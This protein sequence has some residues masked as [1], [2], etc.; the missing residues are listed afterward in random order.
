MVQ[1]V[2]FE[3]EQWMDT[4]ETTPNV[5]NIAETCCSSISIDE[6]SSLSGDQ[7]NP[8]KLPTCHSLTYG[9]IRGSSTLRQRVADLCSHESRQC[10][11]EDNVLVTQGAI[12][13]NFL[14]LYSLIEPGDHVICVYPTYQQLYSV[15]ASLG[16]DVSLWTLR[17]DA[18]Y[19]PSID[20]LRALIKDTTKVCGNLSPCHL[21]VELI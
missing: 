15:P 2:P 10:L 9:S 3:V 19:I 8:V 16:A 11:T 18:G 1:F 17:S 7:Q 21:L 14:A 4:Y 20:D 13:A 6:L 5:L 12:S